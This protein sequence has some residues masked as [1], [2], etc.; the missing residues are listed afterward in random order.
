MTLNSCGKPEESSRIEKILVT[1]NFIKNE[2]NGYSRDSIISKKDMATI[3]YFSNSN[4]R[5][6]VYRDK[7]N[8]I[9]WWT[10][11]MDSNTIESAEV[12]ES[13][14]Q[15]MEKLQFVNGK[16]DGVVKYYYEDGR[17]KRTGQFQEGTR[18][19]IWKKY[20][21]E[22][23]LISISKYDGGREINTNSVE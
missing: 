4:T 13:T 3:E 21:A 14:G 7:N 15:I 11:E 19:G 20:G 12:Y 18:V 22:G 17:I 9:R 1:D 10:K 5:I 6:S 8:K 16:I 2:V 23:K